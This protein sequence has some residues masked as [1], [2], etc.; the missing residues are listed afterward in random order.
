VSATSARQRRLQLA[1]AAV[2]REFLLHFFDSFVSMVVRRS[3]EPF[4]RK[5]MRE[6]TEVS[7]DKSCLA[8][9]F[10]TTHW[11]LIAAASSDSSAALEEL[12]QT[13]WQPLHWHLRRTGYD[14]TEAED[15][16]Q[17]FF[18]RLLEKRILDLADRRRGRFRTF[19][20]TALRRFVIN[21]WKHAAAARRGGGAPHVEIS[22]GDASGIDVGH[23][24]TPDR[25]FDRQW[26]LVVLREAFRALESEAAEA[27]NQ[28]QFEA[29]APLMTKESENTSYDDLSSQLGASPG[30]LRMSVSRMRTR[31]R[32]LLRAEIRKTV[33]SDAEI[34]EEVRSLFR[35]LQS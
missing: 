19:L 7:R 5:F 32:E 9:N 16:T 23:N 12:C 26:A 33:N 30:A 4:S 29:L 27:G 1:E 11:S 28:V 34:D 20:L 22:P 24:Q 14:E 3:D 2:L 8:K 21:E 25:F 18:A 15:L 10:L 35:A 6:M 13:Y 31:L 17:A